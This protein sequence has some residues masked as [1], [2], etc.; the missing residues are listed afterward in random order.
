V[1]I[2]AGV[3]AIGA[4]IAF[5]SADRVN[6]PD[7]FGAGKRGMYILATALNA[8]LLFGC[9]AGLGGIAA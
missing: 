3:L 1:L 5:V 7:N 8:I 4:A 9:I 2:V 6:H